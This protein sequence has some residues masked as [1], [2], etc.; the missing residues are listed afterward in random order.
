[1]RTVRPRLLRFA[2]ELTVFILLALTLGFASPLRAQQMS[3][4]E[5]GQGDGLQDLAVTSLA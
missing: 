5:F 3:L 2:R 1:M 4:Q